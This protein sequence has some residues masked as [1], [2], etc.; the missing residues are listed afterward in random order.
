MRKSRAVGIS[1]VIA[2]ISISTY[3]WINQNSEFNS[4]ITSHP[5]ALGGVFTGNSTYYEYYQVNTSNG[6]RY[7]QVIKSENGKI[8]KIKE[9]S[10]S[11]YLVYTGKAL[12]MARSLVEEK[13]SLPVGAT[14][15]TY[16][17][18]NLTVRL[19]YSIGGNGTGTGGSESNV[20]STLPSPGKEFAVA[21][22]NLTSGNVSVEFVNFE[23]LPRW[24]QNVVKE[25]RGLRK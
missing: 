15:I 24:V 11:D 10:Y 9:I 6:T 18:T 1:L 12:D 13:A 2:F 7:Y 17:V 22:V 3:Y 4:L 16:N 5:H 19:Y 21:R 25:L 8:L 20:T 23:E 14:L